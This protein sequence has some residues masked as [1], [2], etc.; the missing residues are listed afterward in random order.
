MTIQDQIKKAVGAHGMWK[1]RLRE[2]IEAGKSE[3]TVAGVTRDDN[4]EFGKWLRGD[5]SLK[6]HGAHY[7]NVLQLHAEFHKEVGRVLA[8]ALGGKKEVA[9]KAIDAGTPF[10][11]LSAKLTREMV[12]WQKEAA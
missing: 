8:L 3:F 1:N 10:A 7:Q 2:V 11:D 9:L 12:A 4:C 6:S 5:F